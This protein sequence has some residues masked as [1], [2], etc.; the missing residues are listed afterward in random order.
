MG[1]DARKEKSQDINIKFYVIQNS[2]DIAR[3]S[4]RYIF[5][6][7]LAYICYLGLVELSGKTTLANIMF[8][9]FSS[10]ESDFGAPWI[11]TL[12]FL[13]WALLER[14]ERRR[15]TQMLDKRIKELELRIDPNRT[16]SELLPTGETNPKDDVV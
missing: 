15:K 10:K 12:S 7:I 6:L 2:F 16:S 4:L 1:M 11:L 5:L 8:G 13:G 9:Y 3:R 14:R